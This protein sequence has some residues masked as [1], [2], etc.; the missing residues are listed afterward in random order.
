MT[1]PDFTSAAMEPFDVGPEID[2]AIA[3]K[4]LGMCYALAKRIG[5]LDPVEQ[6]AIKLKVKGAFPKDFGATDWNKFVKLG[7]T[8][9]GNGTRPEPSRDYIPDWRDLLLRRP[10]TK[11]GRGLPLS[12]LANAIAA[13]AHAPE[14]AGVVAYDE[15]AAKITIQRAT[16]CG[17]KPGDSWTDQHDRKF[18]EWLQ[19]KE[20]LVGTQI[21]GEAVQT[22]ATDNPYHPCREYLR[23]LIWD[24]Q[25][26][27]DWWLLSYMGVEPSEYV[28]AVGR[29]WMVSAVARILN[30]GCK[31]DTVLVMEGKQGAKKS[32]AAS[33]LFTPW[34]CDH[35]PELSSKD[36][37]LQLSGMW[38][39][40]LAELNN[41]S[42]ADMSHVKSFL[43]SSTD[44]FRMPYGHRAIDVPRSTV[45]LGTVNLDTY[46]RDETGNR[47]FWPVRC[48]AIDLDGLR[49]DRDQL[50][51]EAV[52]RYDAG[53][54]WW[55][56]TPELNAA[57]EEEQAERFETGH[58]DGIVAK[59]VANLETVSVEDILTGCVEKPKAQWSQA[60]KNAVQRCLVSLGWQRYQKRS[61]NHRE[62]RYRSQLSTEY[63][64][65]K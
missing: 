38:C 33:I 16:P 8:A 32:Q 41:I 54:K 60:D 15:F 49:A 39:I 31:V 17:G 50:W 61:E 29:C 7:T 65:P 10:D 21:A 2:A 44:R 24:G 28:S 26:R 6:I 43:S 3:A 11:D 19:R 13:L 36:S 34:F 37:F 14:W 27:L 46:L 1:T 5:T 42:R 35:L 64:S 22:V 30:P 62:W 51:A 63:N 48:G 4:D 59:W 25:T 56:T 12:V 40:E 55:L 45:F 9:N 47:R 52:T 20:I 57:A 18:T 58:W 23:G 53:E